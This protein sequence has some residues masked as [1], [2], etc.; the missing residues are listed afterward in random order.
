MA[1]GENNGQYHHYNHLHRLSSDPFTNPKTASEQSGI[2]EPHE[3]QHQRVPNQVKT[4]KSLLCKLVTK[5][6][7]VIF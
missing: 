6:N 3:D 2:G 4:N 1:E 7:V 5:S